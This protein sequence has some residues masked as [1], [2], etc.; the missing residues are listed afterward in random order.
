MLKPQSNKD[1]HKIK[2]D[3]LDSRVSDKLQSNFITRTQDELFM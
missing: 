3:D 2:G 1:S